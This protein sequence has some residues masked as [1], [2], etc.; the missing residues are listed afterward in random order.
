MPTDR[1]LHQVFLCTVVVTV[2]GG[3]ERPGDRPRKRDRRGR[4]AMP[5]YIVV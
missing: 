3:E 1:D 4:D 2:A 5:R